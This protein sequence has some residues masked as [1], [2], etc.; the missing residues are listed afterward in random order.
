MDRGDLRAIVYGVKRVGHYRATQ[1]N[2]E[3]VNHIC[4]QDMKIHVKTLHL[5]T[6]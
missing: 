1:R 5:F 2:T 4:F 3:N 6:V